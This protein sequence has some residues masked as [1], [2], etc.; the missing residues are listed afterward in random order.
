MNDQQPGLDDRILTDAYRRLT[1]DRPVPTDTVAG[2]RE[3][4]RARHRAVRFRRGL[5]VA[6]AVI[7]AVALVVWPLA[8]GPAPEAPN[9][10]SPDQ[11]TSTSP[12]PRLGPID[13]AAAASCAF[14]YSRRTLGE[15][16]WA[17]DATVSELS[18]HGDQARVTLRVGTWYRGGSGAEITARMPAPV[19]QEDA[20]PGYG[21]GTRLLVS[22]DLDGSTYW[23]WA[24]GFTRYYDQRTATTWKRVFG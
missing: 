3:R 7:A 13:T 11:T 20:P 12:P 15:R 19:E 14:G 10:S 17:A 5:G 4:I 21:V 18:I 6:A 1:A 2:L 9:A 23:G 16:D 24:C 22:G 8:P